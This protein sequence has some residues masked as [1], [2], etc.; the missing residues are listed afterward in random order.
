MYTII[1]L[2]TNNGVTVCNPPQHQDTKDKAMSVYHGIL[3]YAA[4]SDVE[5][6]TVIVVDEHGR[7]LARECYEH[8]NEVIENV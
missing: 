1:E 5:Y 7:Y 8:K 6:H 4:I 3:Q 2:Q